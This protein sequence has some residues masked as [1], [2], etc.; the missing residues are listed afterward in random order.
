M[1]FG[2]SVEER[3]KVLNQM[4]NGNHPNVLKYNLKISETENKDYKVV[5][6]IDY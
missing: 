2:K 6:S 5:K 3:L 1:N 4:H